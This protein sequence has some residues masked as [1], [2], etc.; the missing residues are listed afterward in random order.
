MYEFFRGRVAHLMRKAPSALKWPGLVTFCAS[1]PPARPCRWMVLSWYSMPV[2]WF[3]MAIRNCTAL[4]IQPN[5]LRLIC[6]SPC[7]RLG[8]PLRCRFSPI[9][10]TWCCLAAMQRPCRRSKGSGLIA[11][12]LALEL[13]D[14]VDRISR[15]EDLAQESALPMAVE[16][17]H[18]SPGL[19]CAWLQQSRSG[20]S[21]RPG[22][23]HGQPSEDLIRSA[24]AITHLNGC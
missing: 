5:A 4:P 2:W 1:K 20:R 7:S 3:A 18:C 10:P 21:A 22:H 11:G 8:R 13:H 15:R 6:W 9:G 12:R 23:N 17:R 19:G 14:K 24:L 16:D